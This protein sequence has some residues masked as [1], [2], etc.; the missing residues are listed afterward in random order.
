MTYPPPPLTGKVSIQPTH[1]IM[2]L[3]S[4]RQHI[5]LV[6]LV[7]VTSVGLRA[8]SFS[9]PT[10]I[11]FN[12]RGY[13]TYDLSFFASVV[14][15]GQVFATAYAG[16]GN[17]YA[18]S[19]GSN[20]EAGAGWSLYGIHKVGNQWQATW[21]VKYELR[22]DASGYNETYYDNLPVSSSV[23]VYGDAYSNGYSLPVY[24]QING[25]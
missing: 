19:W 7:L 8:E 6:L 25:Y 1:G 10:Y 16:F 5:G 4:L 14:P 15:G 24:G 11:D 22:S 2:S 3:L 13:A 18:S 20:G 17:L 9:G 23:Y 21:A 12:A